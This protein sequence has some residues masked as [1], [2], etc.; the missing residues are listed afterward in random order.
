MQE[1]Y[2][3]LLD[4]GTLSAARNMALQKVLLEYCAG[5]TVPNT[6][7]FL[8]FSPSVLLGYSQKA[9][10]EVEADYCRENKIEINRRLSG[11][12]CIYMDSGTL[13]WEITAKKSTPGIPA[14]LNGMYRKLCGSVVTA[15][16][17]FGINAVYRPL[18][19]VEIGGRK[20]SG[21][22]GTELDDSFIFHGTILVDFDTGTMLK[23]LKVPDKKCAE[24]PNSGQRTVCLKELL[25]Y[26]PEMDKVKKCLARAFA[27][28]LGIKFQKG[29]LETEEIK[30][31][32]R[33]LPFFQSNDWIYGRRRPG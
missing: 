4:T 29:S 28:T 16:A 20:I 14:A 11:G 27:A 8:Q 21:T 9:E 22:G 7:H 23:A 3:R 13:G 18:N 15:L 30:C 25:G 6:M 2:W 26:A 33:E 5:G 31:L 24:K 32:N 10:D 19:D 17:E 1:S 12:G